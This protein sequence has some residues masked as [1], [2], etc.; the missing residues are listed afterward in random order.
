ME[1]TLITVIVGFSTLFIERLFH[2]LGK[3]KKSHF[4]SSCCV[5]VV[6]VEY[7]KENNKK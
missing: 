7:D 3:T 5:D 4:K 6:N 2:Y 1:P